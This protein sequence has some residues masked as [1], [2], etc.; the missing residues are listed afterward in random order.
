MALTSPPNGPDLPNLFILGSQGSLAKN[1]LLP[2][3]HSSTTGLVEQVDR[4]P[5]QSH[6]STT[7]MGLGLNDPPEDIQGLTVLLRGIREMA[8]KKFERLASLSGQ[9]LVHQVNR[10]VGRGN[11]SREVTEILKVSKISDQDNYYTFTKGS[12]L[13]SDNLT[14]DSAYEVISEHMRAQGSMVAYFYCAVP[15]SLYKTIIEKLIS[16]GLL[17]R[18]DD[19][20]ETIFSRFILEKP[21]GTNLAV[22][23]CLASYWTEEIKKGNLDDQQMVI[24]DH[25]LYKPLIEQWLDFGS[26]AY[27]KGLWDRSHISQV[28]ISVIENEEFGKEKSTYEELGAL[29]DMIQNHLLKL[30]CVTVA[31]R[32][33]AVGDAGEIRQVDWGVQDVEGKNIL[34][35]IED[36]SGSS[37]VLGQYEDADAVLN[38]NCET[39]AAVQFG[40]RNDDWR[41]V[42]F[43]LRT[44]K[45]LSRKSA[46]IKVVFD[47]ES[48]LTYRL[49][50][51]PEI[52]LVVGGDTGRKLSP[53]LKELAEGSS[54]EFDT[55][56]WHDGLIVFKH[57]KPLTSD[58]LAIWSHRAILNELYE[59][60]GVQR[61]VSRDWAQAAWQ[62]VDQIRDVAG[63]PV[64]YPKG[65]HGPLEADFL[66][67]TAGLGWLE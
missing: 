63:S 46:S 62:I 7:Q 24:V 28:Q 40:I 10:M 52:A 61:V 15:P 51:D 60:V 17:S 9:G 14:S 36:V 25:Y 2:A 30:L 31:N 8:N 21:F 29:G 12:P 47:D 48:V 45:A 22:A 41:D 35:D 53:I 38:S 44:G 11:I 56:E 59:P 3:V 4:A 49:Q 42:S 37:V 13:I 64:V 43:F 66:F 33:Q 20:N 32:Q 58:D 5:S 39:Y 16:H 19:R 50:P 54:S 55:K 26:R 67:G 34:E 23:K 27:H 6:I 57:K 65:S 1:K 18:R